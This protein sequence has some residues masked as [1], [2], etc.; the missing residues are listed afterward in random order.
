MTL[1]L[2]GRVAVVTGA[3]AG[4]GRAHALLL[5][6]QGA[7]VVVNDL[8]SAMDGSGENMAAADRVVDEIRDAGGEAVANYDSVAMKEGGEAIVD[9][10]LRAFGRIDVLV[11]NAGILRD[12]SFAKANLDDFRAVFDVHYWG[13][14]FC[15]KAAWGHM[16]DQGYGRVIFTT[17]VAGTSGNFGQANYGSA[18]EGLLGLMRTLAIEGAK[19][20]VLV[21]AVSP[22]ARSRMTENL[23]IP[24]DY[25]AMLDPAHVSPAVAYLASEACQDTG[26]IVTA[27]AGGFGRLHYFE[28]QGV[29]FDPHGPASVEDV[30]AAW[31]RITAF[32]GLAPSE[33]G[34]AG[35]TQDRLATLKK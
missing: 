21:N 33:F 15:T 23:G 29:Q 10:A 28:S 2:E 31:G 4:L 11:N 32:E 13:G 22:G 16:L 12:K 3:G 24:E 30:A 27:A 20:N 7:K 14:V 6:K 9:A 5:A 17:S 35:R 1:R 8:G 26:V 19:K 25:L 18:K 34:A